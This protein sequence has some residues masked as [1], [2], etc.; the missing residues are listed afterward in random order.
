[1]TTF[2]EA[3]VQGLDTLVRL[4]RHSD[5]FRNCTGGGCF[6]MAGNFLHTAVESLYRAG[7][8]D[9]YDIGNDAL[10]FF[11]GYIKDTVHPR[12]WRQ[13]YGYWVDDYGW[14]G[15]AF[16][17][18]YRFS[19]KLGYD[20]SMQAKF[21]K[22]AQNCWEALNA[23]WDDSKIEWEYDHKSYSI[24]GG[25]PNT[26]GGGLLSGRNCVTNECYWRLSAMLGDTFGQ[27]YLDPNAN[28]N[29]FF[30]EAKDQGILF[31]GSGLVYERFLGMPN[32]DHADWT[33]VGDQG[34]FAISCY[35]N[36]QGTPGVFDKAQ[37]QGTIKAV[38]Q[39][40]MTASGV[41]HEDLAP[42]SQFEL[43]Y[44]CGKGTFMRYLAYIN[45]DLHNPFPQQPLY[46]PYIEL[47]AK[48]LWKNRQPYK[49]GKDT[50]MV[51]PYYWDAE[52]PEPEPTSW[53]YREDTARAV[54]HAAGLSAI[55]AGLP[56]FKE[57]PID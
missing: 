42:Y 51:F 19:D 38:Q 21:A 20:S 16:I 48:A 7:L 4:W 47:N 30:L 12:N 33:W 24:T 6:W 46:N 18:A 5:A 22:N 13:E 32:S 15:I 49:I 41:L 23:C 25:I 40:K 2:Q 43:D 57:E 17:T 11:N 9:T 45:D 34:L 35:F 37:A 8:K 28:A 10:C 54:L 36:N 26:T 52:S 1:M 44:A 53:G 29:N 3:T 56:Y 31:D 27:H 50:V 39:N 55:I 14:W